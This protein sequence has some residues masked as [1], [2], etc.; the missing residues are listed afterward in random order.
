MI[1][2]SGLLVVVFHPFTISV[3]VLWGG[4]A[5]NVNN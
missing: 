4:V 5:K 3:S 1:G 2:P